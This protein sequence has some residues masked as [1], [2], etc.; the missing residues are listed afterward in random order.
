MLIKGPPGIIRCSASITLQCFRK[1]KVKVFFNPVIFYFFVDWYHHNHNMLWW[2]AL[3]ILHRPDIGCAIWVLP[4]WWCTPQGLTYPTAKGNTEWM[5]SLKK[6]RWDLAI[7]WRMAWQWCRIC[8]M[9]SQITANF[10]F[11][12]KACSVEQQRKWQCRVDNVTE[13]GPMRSGNILEHGMTMMSHKHH[14]FSDHCQLHS[15]FKSLLS[16]TTKKMAM[17]SG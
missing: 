5:M 10:P 6:G 2:L 16:R 17:Q 11:C 4:L 8:I 7:S 13:K 9:A 15:L 1:L 12:S 14:G 3:W